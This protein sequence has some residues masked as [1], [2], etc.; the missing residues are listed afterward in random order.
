M[1]LIL[2]RVA[3]SPTPVA[4]PS[5]KRDVD[6][7]GFAGV[8]PKKCCAVVPPNGTICALLVPR[9]DV[10]TIGRTTP[11]STRSSSPKVTKNDVTVMSM[12]SARRRSITSFSCVGTP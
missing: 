5:T 10:E 3:M 8:P 2:T 6:S 9:R 12:S 1:R 4:D 11:M 7:S